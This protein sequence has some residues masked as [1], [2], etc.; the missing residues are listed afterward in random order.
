MLLAK[1]HNLPCQNIAK[2]YV[3]G[4]SFRAVDERGELFPGD[5]EFSRK[6]WP[7]GIEGILKDVSN[8]SVDDPL[9]KAVIEEVKNE[10]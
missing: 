3:A 8:L 6:E 4:C 1:K 10:A 9:E 5:K 7:K 2:S